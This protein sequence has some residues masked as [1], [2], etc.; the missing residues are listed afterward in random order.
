MER[1]GRWS[2]TAL[3]VAALGVPV[4]A[5]AST[6]APPAWAGKPGQVRHLYIFPN[7]NMAPTPDE[8]VNPFGAS[9]AVVSLGQFAAGWQDPDPTL[10][11]PQKAGAPGS[12]AWD[13]GNGPVGS[14]RVTVP[15]RNVAAGAGRAGYGV[16]LQVNVV[17][18]TFLPRL[19]SLSAAGYSLTNLT[20]VD[21]LAFNDPGGWGQW[22][23]RTWTARIDNVRE[24]YVTLIIAADPSSGSLIDS[25]E[26]YALADDH[27]IWEGDGKTPIWW[28]DLVG[29]LNGDALTVYEG[30]L[31]NQQDLDRPFRIVSLGFDADGHPLVFWE[32]SGPARGTIQ[33]RVGDDLT[34]D[35][36][37]MPAAGETV[38]ADGMN[39][40]RGA[41]A[42]GETR[43]FFRLRIVAD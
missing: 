39:T 8:S 11:P 5:Q 16:A 33:A 23:N 14:I 34:N 32:S 30:Y 2:L 24:D 20:A 40:W 19:P 3:L 10:N 7:N 21:T 42:R 29:G 13:L 31:L 15:I 26:I 4:D 41:N 18:Y 1:F 36:S 22:N 35:E 38:H 25:I 17:G 6:P 9:S 27:K 37:W 43:L 12:G 28:A